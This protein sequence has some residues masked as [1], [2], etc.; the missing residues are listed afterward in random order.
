MRFCVY[1]GSRSGT[2]PAFQLAAEELA[3]VL[4][5]QG[6]G[7]VYGGASIGLMGVMAN[8]VL[9]RGGEVIGVIPETLMQP[10][11]VHHG[12]TSLAVVPSMHARK[13]RM[14]DLADGVLALPGGLGTLEELLEALT[15]SQLQFHAKP[16]GLLNVCDYFGGLLQCLDGAVQHGFLSQR[17]RALPLVESDPGLLV[18]RMLERL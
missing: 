6:I 2:D 8:A 15:W 16:C 17:N 5:N 9:S 12:L 14:I 13:Q 3:S 18:Q 7:L 4:V 1:C 10:D 11:V